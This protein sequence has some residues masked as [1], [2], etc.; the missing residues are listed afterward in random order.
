LLGKV[1]FNLLVVIMIFSNEG[2]LQD[3]LISYL[4]NR[5]EK[6]FKEFVLPNGGR[7]DILTD[8]YVIECKH[9]LNSANLYKAAGQLLGRYMHN[10]PGRKAVIAGL[11][12]EGGRTTAES[13]RSSGTQVWFIDEIE[14][15]Q[16]FYEEICGY[17]TEYEIEE[18]PIFYT[19]GNYSSN[20]S[21]ESGCF[22]AVVVA[23]ILALFVGMAQ[24]NN[25]INQLHR[26]AIEW[27]FNTANSAFAALRDTEDECNHLLANRVESELYAAINSGLGQEEI[28]RRV[29]NRVNAMQLEIT[30]Q[31]TQCAYSPLNH[32]DQLP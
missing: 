26:A 7:V 15:I 6:C 5:G 32:P 8:H 21:G 13:L 28:Y 24:Y 25:P 1:N 11:A 17:P 22:G 29:F 23:G 14:D 20:S 9:I 12:S 2:D 4:E 31:Y 16:D 30:Q 10:F 3:F 27:D 19:S 18:E